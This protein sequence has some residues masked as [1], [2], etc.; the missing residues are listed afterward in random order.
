M[1]KMQYFLKKHSTTI[2][3]GCGV[4]GVVGT[5]VLAVKATPKA[6]LLLEDAKQLKGENLTPVEVIKVAWKPYIPAVLTGVGTIACIC[7]INYLSTKN[8][9][10][11]MS[12][13]ALLEQGYREY[14]DKVGN[15][16]GEEADHKVKEQIMQSRIEEG[17]EKEE[18]KEWFFDFQSMQFFKSTMDDVLKAESAFIELLEN[19]GYACLNDYYDLLGI[20]HI[21]EGYQLGWYDMENIDPYG[22]EKLEF[23]Y[24]K[25]S[26][27]DGLDCWIID[28]NN[29]PTTDFIL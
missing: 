5:S 29:P 21:P 2:L 26:R 16:Y 9:A 18:N 10:T 4:A 17:L 27:E 25:T 3:T 6:M 23:D 19:K 8:Q 15:L 1:N 13:Y 12:A 14:R 24:Y 20:P 11:L 22:C 28:M 7:G